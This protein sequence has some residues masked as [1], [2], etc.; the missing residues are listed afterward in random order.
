MFLTPPESSLVYIIW[1]RIL[2]KGGENMYNSK[3]DSLN[4]L[5]CELRSQL[6]QIYYDPTI[7]RDEVLRLSIE[8][9]DLIVEYQRLRAIE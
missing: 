2:L 3:I 1:C 5:I 6:E 4:L 8:L 9:D 7:T